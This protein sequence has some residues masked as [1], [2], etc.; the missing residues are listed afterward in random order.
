MKKKTHK[1]AGYRAATD[2]KRCS[3]CSM[4]TTNSCT[5]VEKPIRPQDTC[6]YFEPNGGKHAA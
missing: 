6:D 2:D 4:Y 5:L 3:K 1:E